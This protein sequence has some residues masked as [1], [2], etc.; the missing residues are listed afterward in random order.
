MIEKFCDLDSQLE[1]KIKMKYQL[2]D[3]SDNQMYYSNDPETLKKIYNEILPLEAIYEV[4]E[5]SD[6]IVKLRTIVSENLTED[7]LIN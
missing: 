6:N 2:L 5:R 4:I 1:I 7:D 3:T